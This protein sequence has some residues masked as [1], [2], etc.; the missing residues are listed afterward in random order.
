MSR[1]MS[2][3]KHESEHSQAPVGAALSRT[4]HI[5]IPI[6]SIVVL[7]AFAIVLF[8]PP[9]KSTLPV[10]STLI[11]IPVYLTIV[12]VLVLGSMYLFKR[13]MDAEAEYSATAH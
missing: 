8:Q 3:D 7:L 12:V 4:I 11:F 6:A 2:E 1:G 9:D 5:S 10:E 13:L